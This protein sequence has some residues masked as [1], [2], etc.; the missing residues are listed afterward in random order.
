[1]ESDCCDQESSSPRRE[2]SPWGRPHTADAGLG[3]LVSQLVSSLLSC[4]FCTKNCY[5][6]LFLSLVVLLW[7]FLF[8]FCFVLFFNF[9]TPH[10]LC[11]RLPSGFKASEISGI[12]TQRGDL[13]I[14]V[15]FSS[16][17]SFL[18]KCATEEIFIFHM[19]KCVVR[20]DS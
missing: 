1:M 18:P 3:P 16:I 7:F 17:C 20:R 2:S 11:L 19:R 6:S 14:A 8:V 5:F 10:P 9:F 4:K 15:N 12:K 13:G